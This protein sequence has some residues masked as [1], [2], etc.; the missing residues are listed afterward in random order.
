MDP[1][2]P[3]ISFHGANIIRSDIGLLTDGNWL[4]D[5]IIGFRF[6]QLT[7]DYSVA[8]DGL[9]KRENALFVDP[10]GLSFVMFQ[11][12]E[13]D[14]DE[15]DEFTSG[16][17]EGKTVDNLLF[18]PISSEFVDGRRMQVGAGV[19]WSLLVIEL[20][21]SK[22]VAADHYDSSFNSNNFNAA[23]SVVE[24]IS[25]LLGRSSLTVTRVKG[26]PQQCNGYDCGVYLL[27]FSQFYSSTS[28]REDI[29]LFVDGQKVTQLR[30]TIKADIEQLIAARKK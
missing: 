4:N 25:R 13:N 22:L 18:L 24:K 16:I 5:S 28:W 29:N 1:F 26:V 30:N 9:S 2:A 19:H 8:T 3:L 15:R 27:Y 12:D 7:H 11:L 21:D 17:L 10:V 6:A 14:D 23:Q 20:K